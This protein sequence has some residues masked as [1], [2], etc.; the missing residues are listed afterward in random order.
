MSA[1]LRHRQ[2]NPA[3]VLAKGIEFVREAADTLARRD[4][5]AGSSVWLDSALYPDYY[6]NTF[7]YQT[8][9]WFSERSASVYETSTETLFLGRQVRPLLNFSGD[10]KV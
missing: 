8:D 6:K 1:A 3:Y 7:H 2:S 4:Q 9:G 5:Q 10:E